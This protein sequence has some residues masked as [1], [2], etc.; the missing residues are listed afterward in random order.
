MTIKE[1]Y[2]KHFFKDLTNE[3]RNECYFDQYMWHAFSYKKIEALEGVQAIKAFEEI[4]KNG[5]YIF[6][7]HNNN[8]TEVDNISFQELEYNLKKNKDWEYDCYVVDKHFKWTFV[9]THETYLYEGKNADPNVDYNIY[10]IGP[11]YYKIN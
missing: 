3:D 6:F 11:F 5:V 4:S 8:V 9:Y 10:Y 1:K 2:I 7:E